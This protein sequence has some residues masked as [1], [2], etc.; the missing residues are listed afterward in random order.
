[1]KKKLR[2]ASLKQNLLVVIKEECSQGI[3]IQFKPWGKTVYKLH[4][5]KILKIRFFDH[6][7]I[8]STIN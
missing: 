5:T 6:H 4:L 2:T 1:M 3:Q 8:T 7:P